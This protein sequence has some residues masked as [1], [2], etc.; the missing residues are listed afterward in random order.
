LFNRYKTF[1]IPLSDP[2]LFTAT[3]EGRAFIAADRLGLH[4]GTAGLMAASSFIDIRVRLCRKHVRQPLLL[5]L[6]GHDRIV[7]NVRTRATVKTLASTDQTIIEY[8][9]AHHT[10]EFEPDP[11]RYARDLIAWLDHKLAN[12]GGGECVARDRDRNDSCT[13]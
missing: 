12:P 7:D 2:E 3:P 11:S 8:P 4:A 6:A 13:V 10:L 9:E 5:M 1:P